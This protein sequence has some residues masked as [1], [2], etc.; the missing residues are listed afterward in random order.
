MYY[1]YSNFGSGKEHII[2]PW[3]TKK[4]VQ[5]KP[6]SLCGLYYLGEGNDIEDLLEI[7]N[8]PKLC[9][10]CKKRIEK[11]LRV[12]RDLDWIMFKMNLSMI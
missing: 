6:N 8:D 5:W 12:I 11:E 10:F 1:K 2:K 4:G 7:I 9:K 3:I